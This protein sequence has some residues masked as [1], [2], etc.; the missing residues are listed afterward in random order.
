MHA[1]PAQI[2]LSKKTAMAMAFYCACPIEDDCGFDL[3]MQATDFSVMQSKA[4]GS[5]FTH[6][7]LDGFPLVSIQTTVHKRAVNLLSNLVGTTAEEAIV[8]LRPTTSACS[9]CAAGA[10]Q[11]RYDPRDADKPEHGIEHARLFWDELLMA[12]ES[13]SAIAEEFGNATLC[14]CMYLQN[15]LLTGGYIDNDGPEATS[16]IV[17]LVAKL[18]SSETWTKFIHVNEPK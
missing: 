18:P 7:H 10:H 14:D 1:T 3:L 9:C 5:V 6:K 2:L 11:P 15:A 4:W 8:A 13:L 17:D 16:K 12:T